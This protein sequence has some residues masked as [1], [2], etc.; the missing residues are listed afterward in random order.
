MTTKFGNTEVIGDLDESPFDEVTGT[1]APLVL[2]PP[3][4]GLKNNFSQCKHARQKESSHW[5]NVWKI[6][7]LSM[8]IFNLYSIWNHFLWILYIQRNG[9]EKGFLDVKNGIM[10]HFTK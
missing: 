8:L 9:H 10:F 5:C 3:N 2:A 4:V 7:L 6:S 1:E